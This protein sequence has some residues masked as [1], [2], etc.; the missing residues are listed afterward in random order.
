MKVDS[1]PKLTV[2]YRMYLTPDLCH[3]LHTL[4]VLHLAG[5]SCDYE[6]ELRSGSFGR[7]RLS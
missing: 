3:K 5:R 6:K 2:L 4:G 1:V 7:T